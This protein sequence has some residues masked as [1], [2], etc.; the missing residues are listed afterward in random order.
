MTD[1]ESL[2]RQIVRD[3]LAKAKPANDDG[4]Y[5]TTAEAARIA[6]VTPGTIRRW[7]REGELTRHE[8]GARVRVKRDELEAF[9]KC[10]VVPIDSKLSPD[11]RIRRKFG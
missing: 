2:V 3:E 11:E 7:I 6:S 9:L 8:A 10:D 1:L 5:L 4:D